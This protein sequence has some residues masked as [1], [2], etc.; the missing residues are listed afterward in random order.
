MAL[1][2][3]VF[4]G[5]DWEEKTPAD[6]GFDSEK[7]AAVETWLRQTSQPDEPYHFV[8][9]RSGYLFAEWLQN[10]DPQTHQPQ[11]SA[12]KSYYSSM[13]AIAV[14][15]GKIPS[16]DAK[17]VDYYPAMMDVPPGEGPKEGRHAFDKDREITFRQLICN[18]SGYM[19]PGEEPGQVFH[20]QTYG[21]NILTHALAVLYDLYDVQDPERLPG[22][23]QLIKDKIRNPIAGTWTYNYTNFDLHSNARLNI[24]GHYTQIRSTA[25]DT[26]RIGW[27]WLNYG[28]WNGQQVVPENYL[29]AATQTNDFI[30]ASEPEEKWGY[31]HGFWVNDYGVQWP[32]LPRDSFAAQGAGAKMTWV[33][34]SLDLVITQ[35]PG[36]WNAFEGD[37]RDER[38]REIL[39]RIIDALKG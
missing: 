11:A 19:K 18:C 20:Y 13:L 29:R 27:L 8:L 22:C 5:V 10:V 35:N 1:T 2:E 38:V 12:A 24:F 39:G 25:R 26:A 14:A 32:D 28:H 21:M 3:R 33:C 34:P 15:E 16:P 30:K 7:L 9:C 4:P 31:G 37:E 6:L 17:V 36:P 23:G